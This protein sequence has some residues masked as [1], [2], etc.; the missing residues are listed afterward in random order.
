MGG[1]RKYEENKKR[2]RER[3]RR[4]REKDKGKRDENR[5]LI[6]G[7][8]EKCVMT[9]MGMPGISVDTLRLCFAER[10]KEE[11]RDVSKPNTAR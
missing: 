11:R 5:Q 1:E 3:A 4:K 6:E 7:R 8:G 2:Q 9:C 10:V